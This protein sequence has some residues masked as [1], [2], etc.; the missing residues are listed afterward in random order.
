MSELENAVQAVETEAKKVETEVVN[1]VKQTVAKVKPEV[2]KGLQEISTEEKL[3]IREIENE[4]LKAQMEINRLSQI[5]QAAQK[6]FTSTVEAL[7]KKYL[8]NPA[9]NVFDNIELKFVPK[10]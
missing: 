9:E 3:A 4:Y 6:R 10:K 5:T 7:T 8:I 2:A 1:E